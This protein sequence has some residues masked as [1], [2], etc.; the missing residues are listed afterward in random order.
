MRERVAHVALLVAGLDALGVGED[1]HLYEVHVVGRA[2]VHLRVPD[3]PP[4]V[5]M[6]DRVLRMTSGRITEQYR[7][8]RRLSPEELAW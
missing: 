4:R 7:N 1:P 8:A 5:R 6:A 2:R 3:A